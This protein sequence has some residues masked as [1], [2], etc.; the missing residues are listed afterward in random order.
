MQTHET[1]DSTVRIAGPLKI[2]SGVDLAEIYRTT[3]K[4]VHLTH[5]KFVTADDSTLLKLRGTS[6]S[7]RVDV[8]R[9]PRLRDVK[10]SGLSI[11]N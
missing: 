4:R 7:G 1:T 3:A 11:T 9:R 2:S 10:G 8:Y 5:I 6:A